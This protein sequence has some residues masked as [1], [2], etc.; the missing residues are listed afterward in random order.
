MA[1]S[2]KEVRELARRVMKMSAADAT[3]VLVTSQSDALTR[4]ANNRVHQNV[5]EENTQVSIRAVAG[6]RQGVA[7]TN[8]LDDESLRAA[9]DA[10]LRAARVAPDDPDFPGLPGADIVRMIDRS[11]EATRAFDADARADAVAAIVAQSR[12]RGLTAAG[13]VRCSD[14]AISVVST[15]GVDVAQALTEAQATVLSMGPDSG[16][17]WASFLDI[18]A[19]NLAAEAIGSQAADIAQRAANPGD[20]APGTYTVVLAP[21]AVADIMDF[22]AYTGFS[23]KSVD[24]GRSFMSGHIGEQVMS[25]H[26]T[27]TDDALSKRAMGT[28]FDF[29]GQPRRKVV[30]V[31]HGIATRPITDSY[32]AARLGVANTGHALPAPNPY[33]PMPMNLEMAAGEESIDSLIAGVERGVYVTRFHYVNVEDPITVLL[34]GMTRD[35]TF[36]IENGRLTRPLKNLR[37]TQSAVEALAS[38]EGVTRD[39]RFIGTE[40]GAVYVPGLLLAR[41]A[42]TGQTS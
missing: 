12:S 42:F 10:A 26:I 7:G 11:A 31:D 35:G 39:R 14:Q 30:L 16:S 28:T 20:L 36:L 17:G 23:A 25:D 4:F 21:D 8:R 5:A 1:L 27:I 34:T 9:C 18:D 32:W 40:D 13:T 37:F 41:F 6:K 24:E 29:E 22:L 33:G 2:S 38:C 19:A 15:L 3:E